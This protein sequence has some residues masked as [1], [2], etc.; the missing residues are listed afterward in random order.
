LIKIIKLFLVVFTI[1]FS[2]VW[3]ADNPG[4][5]KIFWKEYLIQTNLLGIAFVIFIFIF[6]LFLIYILFQKIKAIPESYRISRQGKF[7]KLGN[8][9]LDEMAVNLFIGDSVSL[10]KNARK[11]KK[12]FRN[13]LFSTFMLFN[14]SLIKNDINEA[15]KYL[16][17]LKLIPK[18]EYISKRASVLIY[19]KEKKI[20]EATELLKDYVVDYPSDAWF[21]EK[22]AIIYSKMSE[23]SQAYSLIEN[24]KPN[25]NQR[26]KNLLANLKILS[27]KNALEALR[28]S[29][30]SYF[31]ITESLKKYILDEELKKASVLIE[32]NWI[33][34]NCLQVVELF[35]TFKIKGESDSLNRFKLVAKAIKKGRF[36]SSETNLALAHAAF[37]AGMWGESQVFLDQIKPEE[38]D[39]R[40]SELYNNISKKSV[41]IKIPLNTKSIK[42]EPKWFCKFCKAKYDNWQFIC[43]ECGEVNEIVWPKSSENQKKQ[44]NF[45]NLLQNSFSHFPQMK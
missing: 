23:W 12:Y 16:R 40:V 30:N 9:T 26:L 42:N 13:E 43:K 7:L 44:G 15:K 35:M 37:E 29:N 18:A 31:V 3:L 4:T 2:I 45:K 11:I 8:D 39:I 32:K 25:K 27:G 19:L 10:E 1:S 38:W 24:I 14:T 22:L 36:L 28:I 41:K 6:S 21:A 33:N 34:L 20:E 5:V 17:I